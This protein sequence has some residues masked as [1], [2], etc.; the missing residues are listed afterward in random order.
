MGESYPFFFKKNKRKQMPMM[1]GLTRLL[2]KNF[3]RSRNASF[4]PVMSFDQY[5]K[6]RLTWICYLPRS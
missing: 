4:F 6:F 3:I 2:L 5:P 1:K